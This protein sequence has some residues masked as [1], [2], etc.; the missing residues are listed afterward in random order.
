MGSEKSTGTKII[1]VSGHV[2]RPGNYEIVMTATTLR[3]LIYDICGG[4]PEDR[5][6]KAVIPGGSSMPMLPKE[7]ID[8][9]IAFDALQAA[10]SMLGSGGM[11]VFDETTCI[12]RVATWISRFYAHE[13]CGKCVPCR[14]G[15][16]W[17]AKILGRIETGHGRM[18]DLDLILS[19]CVSLGGERMLDS[20]SFC[21]LGDAAAWPVQWGALKYF[22]PEFEYHIRHRKCMVD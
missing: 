12:P 6:L 17:I 1:S 14:I 18:E 16:D 5:E 11:M 13:S 20:R 2:R 19:A 15:T 21:P 9:P 8:T 22:R 7:L 10:G 4:I 3:E